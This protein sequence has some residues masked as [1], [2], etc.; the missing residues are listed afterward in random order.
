MPDQL[1]P[2]GRGRGTRPMSRA[3]GPAGRSASGRAACSRRTPGMM[4]LD[5]TN[6]WVLRE[7]GAVAVGRRRPRPDRGGPP[8]P[9]RRAD[10]RRRAGAADPPPLRPLRGRRASWRR[11]KGCPVRALDPAYCLRRR[12]ARRRRGHRRR[13]PAAARSCSRPGHTAD[14]I[15]L[16]LPGRAGAA[17]RRHGARPRHDR[18]RLARRPAR[19]LLRVDR[20][21]AR[22]RRLRRGRHALAGP[23]PGA[24]RRPR[25]AR[26]LPRPPPPAARAGRGRPAQLGIDASRTSRTRSCPARSSRSSTRTSTSRSG[27]RPSGRSAPSWPTWPRGSGARASASPS[28]TRSRGHAERRRH[29]SEPLLGPRRRRPERGSRCSADRP[30]GRDVEPSG[31]ERRLRARPA[32]RS[33][34]QPSLGRS[35]VAVGGRVVDDRV[36][37]HRRRRAERPAAVV[38][39][40]GPGAARPVRSTDVGSCVRADVRWRT[41]TTAARRAPPSTHVAGRPASRVRCGDHG[42]R[43]LRT[44]SGLAVAASRPSS[45]T[46]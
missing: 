13:R 23:R 42:R 11:R 36:P 10:R 18:R 38:S 28:S 15:S 20:A 5:G 22:P 17:D 7:P 24:R 4:T 37:D 9:A 25:R 43:S 35:Q 29:T 12:P 31:L 3:P 33:Q 8:R 14:S 45:P 39:V 40:R 32:T 46:A 21:D 41:S 30:V 44:R 6:T 26:L 34:V 16:L 2:A 19:L 27:A 1:R